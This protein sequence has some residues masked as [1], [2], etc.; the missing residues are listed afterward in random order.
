MYK[1]PRCNQHP[2][3]SALKDGTDLLLTL[4]FSH[5]LLVRIGPYFFC[6][7]LCPVIMVWMLFRAL[8]CLCQNRDAVRS[9]MDGGGGYYQEF[10]YEDDDE[11]D[12]SSNPK[13]LGRRMLKLSRLKRD[14]IE[15]TADVIVADDLLKQHGGDSSLLMYYDECSHEMS[16]ALQ[17]LPVGPSR[18]QMKFIDRFARVKTR[19]AALV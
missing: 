8:C 14:A 18:T 3:Y 10:E 9:Y 17:R 4:S 7:V 2:V 13:E 6:F 19:E 15:A 1:R 5:K 11:D 16:R 12:D